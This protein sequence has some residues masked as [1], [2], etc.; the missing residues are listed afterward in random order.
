[1]NDSDLLGRP[2]DATEQAVLEVYDRLKGL[3]RSPD[4]APCVTANARYALAAVWQI[5]NDLNLEHEQ[6]DD[7]GV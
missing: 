1:M 3:V 6:L 5:V 7:L 4:A 2:I